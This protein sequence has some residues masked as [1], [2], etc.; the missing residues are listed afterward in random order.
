ML[1][2][3]HFTNQLN[4]RIRWDT[5]ERGYP[6][7]SIIGGVVRTTVTLSYE[8]R[9]SRIDHRIPDSPSLE[10]VLFGFSLDPEGLIQLKGLDLH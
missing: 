2:N 9:D 8:T 3:S 5:R 10:L 4:F 1:R 6:D 7:S